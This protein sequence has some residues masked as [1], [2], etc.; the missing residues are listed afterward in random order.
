MLTMECEAVLLEQPN[1]PFTRI[2]LRDIS[3]GG[4]SF[5]TS[6]PFRDDE[7]LM[8]VMPLASRTGRTILGRVRYCKKLNDSLYLAGAEFLDAMNLPRSQ[9]PVRIPP[10]W[11][12]PRNDKKP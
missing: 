12:M 4:V 10:K 1:R 6:H 5:D 9:G 7:L 2:I 11:L 8:I 3:T